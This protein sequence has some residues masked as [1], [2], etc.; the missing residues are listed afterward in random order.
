MLE[1]D[2]INVFYKDVHVL[3][4]ISLQIF[5][6]EI[7]TVIGPNG[8][9]KSTLLKAVLNLLPFSSG[10]ERGRGIRFLGAEIGSLPPEET[11]RL[12]IAIVPEG[13]YVVPRPIEGE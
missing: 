8:A 6:G 10:S 12:G 4:D 2:R 1:I 13:P 11:V 9:G 7:V 5:S 3:R